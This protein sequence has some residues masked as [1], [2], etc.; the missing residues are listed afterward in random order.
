MDAEIY[1]HD[2]VRPLG[3][4]RLGNFYIDIAAN[5]PVYVT[6]H[7]IYAVKA[8]QLDNSFHLSDVFRLSKNAQIFTERNSRGMS[9][10]HALTMRKRISHAVRQSGRSQPQGQRREVEV[11]KLN[12]MIS[13]TFGWYFSQKVIFCLGKNGTPAMKAAPEF[14]IK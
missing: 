12:V 5:Y 4:L 14:K 3:D 1:L 2:L 7:F 8:A 9:V 11:D 13:E 6:A 10:I